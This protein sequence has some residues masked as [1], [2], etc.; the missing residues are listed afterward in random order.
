LLLVSFYTSISGASCC[1]VNNAVAYLFVVKIRVLDFHNADC[2]K[3]FRVA[4]VWTDGLC[5]RSVEGSL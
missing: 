5:H 1:H 3:R 4:A 2:S